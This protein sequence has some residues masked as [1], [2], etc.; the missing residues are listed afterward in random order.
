MPRN[1]VEYG[2]LLRGLIDRHDVH[3]WLVNTGW[4]GGPYGVGRRMPILWTRTLLDAALWR[5]AGRRSVPH[6]FHGSASRCR[7]P[8]AGVPPHTLNP[9]KT[10]A[11]KEAFHR[12]AKRLV[13]MFVANFA[14]FEAMVDAEVMRGS[15]KHA[16]GL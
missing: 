12:Q 9:Y 6:R 8:F 3:C 13:D 5:V 11:D 1:P 14:K 2:N 7:P 15:P 4:T 10:W 16:A